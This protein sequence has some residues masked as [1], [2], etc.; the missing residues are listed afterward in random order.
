ME[1]INTGMNTT[2][3]QANSA[4]AQLKVHCEK[5]IGGEWETRTWEN[6]GWHYDVRQN[7]V[8]ISVAHGN[9]FICY[10]GEVGDSGGYWAE[11]GD[12]V[13]ESLENSLE[14]AHRRLG[15]LNRAMQRGCDIF[16]LHESEMVSI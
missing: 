5:E 9:G 12:T 14:E 10:I 8:T 15:P 2:F 4:A 7:G 1:F 13:R 16:Q 11:H 3:A 6:I